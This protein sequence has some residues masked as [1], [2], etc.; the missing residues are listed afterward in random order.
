MCASGKGRVRGQGDGL[1]MRV[2][3]LRSLGKWQRVN[4]HDIPVDQGE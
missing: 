1:R 3:D 4:R 2:R